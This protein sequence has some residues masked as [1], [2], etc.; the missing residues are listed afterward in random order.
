MSYNTPR[1]QRGTGLDYRWDEDAVAKLPGSLDR[2]VYLSG[3]I[4]S[5]PALAGSGGGNT[6]IKLRERDFA[7]RE[8]GALW[9]KSRGVDLRDITRE[10]FTALALDETRSL[11]D[12]PAMT[13]EAMMEFLMSC[14]L[15]ARQPAPS[16]ETPIHALLPHR[17]IAHTHDLPTQCL[18]DTTKKDALVREA[19]G[20]Q[21]AYLGYV[22]S[23]FPMVKAIAAVGDLENKRGIVLGKRG[24]ITWGTTPKECYDNL[25]RLISLMETAIARARAMRKPLARTRYPAGARPGLARQVLPVLRGLLS[26][27]KRVV[28][29]LD[30]SDE[31][32]RFANSELAKNVHR[33]GM[34]NPENI[35]RCGRQPMYVDDDLGALEPPARLESLRRAI[36]TFEADTRLA[37]GKHGQGG[38]V[39]GLRPRVCILPGIGIVCAGPDRR[40]AEVSAQNYRQVMEVIEAAEALDQFR[41]ID[42][43]GAME[44]EYWPLELARHRRVD[45]ELAR[46]V[47]FVTGAAGGIGRAVAARLAREGAHVAMTDLDGDAVR[48]AAEEVGREVGDPHRTLAIRADASSEEETRRAFDEAVLAFGGVDILVCN[49]GFVAP[50]AFEATTLETW[51]RTFG[52]NVTGPFLA[53][54]EAVRIMKAQGYGAI[55]M[56]V[57]KAAFS[58]PL[59]NAAYAASKA[60]AYHFMRCLAAELAPAGIRVNAVNADFVDTAMMQRMIAERAAAKGITAEQQ[61]EE[62]RKR[63]LM[64][65]GPIPPEAV[66]DAVVYLASDRARYTTGG[67]LTVDGGLADAMPR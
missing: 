55:V 49:A 64:K 63:N 5:D 29:H 43:A 10:G 11:K 24:L 45:P 48:L 21:V 9:V 19:L 40:S 7:G 37:F 8:V 53:V 50:A 4:G 22:R 16:V 67:V 57:S 14:R 51:E 61:V 47:A 59:G 27:P 25:H 34:A 17:V 66:A 46:R 26:T 3:L 6:S 33:R 23:G 30:A 36:E 56:N 38:E 15:D 20:D 42:E 41:F 18:T 58:A 52:T 62:Y 31:A 54:R 32:L 35:M 60:A 28:L 12:V 2:L 44:F 1:D 65:V 13:D 39:I